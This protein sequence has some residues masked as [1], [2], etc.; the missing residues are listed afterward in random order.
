VAPAKSQEKVVTLDVTVIERDAQAFGSLTKEEFTVYEDEVKQEINSL[1]AQESSVSLGIAIDA[2]G[3]MRT[4]LPLIQRTALNV[5]SQLRPADEAFLVVFRAEAEL[6]HDFTSNQR[7][8]AKAVGEIF[9]SGGTG[10][11]D[12]VVATADYAY[13]KGK[14]RRRAALLITDGIEKNSS[15]NENKVITSL[16]ENRTQAYFICLPAMNPSPLSR[17][18]T[19]S[20][21][22]ERLDRL[23]KAS[24]GLSFPVATAEESVQTAARLMGN[25]RR[26]Y[27]ITYIS[28]NN[29]QD[30]KLRKVRVVVSPKDGRQLNVITR[31]G[32]Y[33]PGH[34]TAAEKE[35]AKKK[36]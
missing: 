15:V 27:E 19:P 32:Y 4:E 22:R 34:K 7:D 8:L 2:S 3:S 36:K 20:E 31:Q 18:K 5:I 1:N 29:K 13:Q 14:H 10:L 26:Q 9:T 28:T 24:G 12:A 25:L 16:I 6:F 21:A 23:A 17:Y 33:G 35:A 11:F 30:D